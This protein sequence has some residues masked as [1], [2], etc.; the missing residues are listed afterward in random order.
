MIF[1]RGKRRLFFRLG[2]SLSLTAT[3]ALAHVWS[4]DAEALQNV[5]SLALAF[6]VFPIWKETSLLRARLFIL[7]VGNC[8]LVHLNAES[9]QKIIPDSLALPDSQGVHKLSQVFFQLAG[10]IQFFGWTATFGESPHWNSW[11]EKKLEEDRSLDSTSSSKKVFMLWS[12]SAWW[13]LLRAASISEAINSKDISRFW[14]S[15]YSPYRHNCHY[16]QYRQYRH[17]RH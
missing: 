1:F 10:A 16:H 13:M 12:A 15:Q 8:R 7:F 14:N 11:I 2:P 6:A 9:P 5:P 17:K 3:V 4:L